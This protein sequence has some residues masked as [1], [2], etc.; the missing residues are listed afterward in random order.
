MKKHTICVVMPGY[1]QTVHDFCS[2]LSQVFDVHLLLPRKLCPQNLPMIEY[3]LVLLESMNLL[4][5]LPVSLQIRQTIEQIKPAAIITGEDFQPNTILLSIFQNRINVPIIIINEKYFLSRISYLKPLHRA[6]RFLFTRP[7]VW[8][9]ACR[10]LPRSHAAYAYSLSNGAP[11][12]KMRVVPMGIHLQEYR[13]VIKNSDTQPLEIISVGRLIPLKRYDILLHALASLRRE[14][15]QVRLTLVGDGQLNRYLRNLCA[16]LNLEDIV[17]FKTHIPH[18]DL[19]LYYKNFDIYIQPSAV[20]VV[21][22]SAL[23]AL[24]AGCAL[25][26]SDCGGLADLVQEDRNGIRVPVGDANALA[27]AINRVHNNREKLKSMKIESLKI[28]ESVFSWNRVISAYESEIKKCIHSN[29]D[30]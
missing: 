28:A 21:G 17:V 5:E 29:L 11:K 7:F 30:R 25:I 6:I 10:I 4:G 9:N 19:V 16:R 13:D 2:R 20:E 22:L 24:A 3:S 14:G 26:V 23:E 15:I 27:N 12:E 18:A 1:H 8:R